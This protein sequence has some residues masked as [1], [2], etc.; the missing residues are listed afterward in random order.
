M[1]HHKSCAAICSH[2][3]AKFCAQEFCLCL[4]TQI[5]LRSVMRLE[6]YPVD[7]AVRSS[8]RLPVWVTGE[9]TEH[10]RNPNSGRASVLFR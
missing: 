5:V 3:A 7:V 9:S 6:A 2:I 1:A 10:R 8:T 4:E